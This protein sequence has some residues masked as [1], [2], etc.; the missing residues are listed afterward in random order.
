[1]LDDDKYFYGKMLRAQLSTYEQLILLFNS[2]SSLGM[3]WEYTPDLKNIPAN[4][5]NEDFRFI[6]RY[7]IIK[8]L[9]GSQFLD[10]TYRH[11]YRDVHYE[12]M[13][14]LTYLKE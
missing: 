1:L 5:K 3:N 11:Y 10:I 4:C 13:D 7:N 8:N 9:P 12:Y 2:V 6:T 14:D